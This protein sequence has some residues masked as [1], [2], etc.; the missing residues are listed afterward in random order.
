MSK[1]ITPGLDSEKSLQK[2]IYLLLFGGK[3]ENGEFS[4]TL[5]VCQSAI[6]L[7]FR[8]LVKIRTQVPSG[9]ITVLLSTGSAQQE[10]E[11]GSNATHI[12][13]KTLKL[14]T[15]KRDVKTLSRLRII[16]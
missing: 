14:I 3:Y 13:K 11:S 10:Q 15:F 7:V 8:V 6:V 9:R 5:T 4:Y 16:Y 2:F 1:L 12:I